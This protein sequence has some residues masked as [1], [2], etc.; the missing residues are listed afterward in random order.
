MDFLRDQMLAEFVRLLSVSVMVWLFWSCGRRFLICIVADLDV[1]VLSFSE[2]DFG[3]ALE[4]GRSPA[5]D[6][7]MVSTLANLSRLSSH[8]CFS[9]N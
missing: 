6:E 8:Y 9:A 7:V 4:R 1:L 5:R 2:C 3:V